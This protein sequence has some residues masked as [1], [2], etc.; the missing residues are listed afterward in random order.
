MPNFRVSRPVSLDLEPDGALPAATTSRPSNRL[1]ARDDEPV[2]TV[3]VEDHLASLLSPRS[4]EADQYRVLRQFLAEAGVARPLRILAVTSPGA[5]DGK[6]TTSINLAAT[7]AQTSGS[8]VLLVDTDLRR[9]FVAANLGLSPTRAGLAEAAVD[10]RLELSDVVQST[11]YNLAVLPAGVPPANPYQALE[12]AR[13]GQLL[14][15]ARDSYEYI[16]LDTPPV[17]LVPDCKLMSQWIDGFLLVVAAHRTPRK[18]LGEALSALDETKL[19]GI[20][21]NGDDRP[22]SGYYGKYY[23]GRYHEQSAPGAGGWR[24]SWKRGRKPGRQPWR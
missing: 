23:S 14:E 21:F 11:P 24:N 7:L 4:Y 9:P 3:E 8:R 18:L 1:S 16:V 10:E 6:T 2:S 5:G 22:L 19:L 13:V 17:L 20:V 12:S 15:Q